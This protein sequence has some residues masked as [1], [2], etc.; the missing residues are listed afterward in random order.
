MSTPALLLWLFACRIPPVDVGKVDT[1]EPQETGLIGN[2]DTDTGEEPES[3]CASAE[4]PWLETTTGCVTGV[5]DGGVESFLGLPYAEPPTG[6]R[7]FLPPE[8][9]APWSVT[10]EADSLGS[11]C[12]QTYDSPDGALLDGEGDEDCLTLNVWRPAGASGLPL[13]FYVHGGNFLNGSGGVPELAESPTLPRD[14]VVVTHNARLGPFGYLAHPGLSAAS[15]EGVSGNQGVLDTLQALRWVN[16]NAETLGADPDRVILVG[17]ESGGLAA[18]AL[19]LSPLAEGWFD[20]VILQSAPCG[21]LS[22][23][24]SDRDPTATYASAEDAGQ[25]LADA[26]G[27]EGT[28]EEQVACLQER[29]ASGVLGALTAQPA[30]FMEGV[31]WVPNIDGYLIPD[32]ALALVAAGAVRDVPVIAGVN[33]DE[34]TRYADAIAADDVSE[35]TLDFVIPRLLEEGGADDDAFPEDAYTVARYGS[36]PDAFIAFYGDFVHTCP[37]RSFLRALAE[38]SDD[39]RAYTFTHTPSFAADGLGAYTGAEIPFLFGTRADEYTGNEAL[40]SAWVQSAWLWSLDTPPMVIGVGEWPD[41]EGDHW[42]L[43]GDGAD[44]GTDDDPYEDPCEAFDLAGWQ[45]Y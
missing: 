37:T 27:C 42:V 13:I 45:R 34:G 2:D 20:G 3:D 19:L 6:A 40:I 33:A 16:E 21:L 38:I 1:D 10:L 28:D 43:F 41:F 29:P 7:R 5:S 31:P 35:F 26:L 11:P 32:T 30:P 15:K 8:P 18:C 36:A 14:A 22:T 23:P 25:A 24:L 9:I 4:A 44:P 39:V 12:L 17:Q